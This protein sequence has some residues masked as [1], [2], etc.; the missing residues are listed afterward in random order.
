MNI[1]MVFSKGNSFEMNS[2]THPVRS[3][4]SLTLIEEGDFDS[5]RGCRYGKIEFVG[6]FNGKEEYM[7]YL[8]P[9]N[10]AG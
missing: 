3:M 4:D 1:L 7:P 9:Y 8:E 5:I 10:S 2:K 6:E